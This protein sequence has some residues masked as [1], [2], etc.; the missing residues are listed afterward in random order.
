MI[1]LFCD[2]LVAG[3]LS[4]VEFNALTLMSYSD[5]TKN[6]GQTTSSVYDTSQQYGA[7]EYHNT[8]ECN[9]N[10]IEIDDASIQQYNYVVGSF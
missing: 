10:N 4:T 6:D 1:W 2:G 8:V 3:L 5:A 7:L 9:L